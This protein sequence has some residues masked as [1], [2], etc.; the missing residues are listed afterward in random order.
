MQLASKHWMFKQTNILQEDVTIISP[1]EFQIMSNAWD[2]EL[3]ELVTAAKNKCWK[4]KNDH[5][6]FPPVVG[7][8]IK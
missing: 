3:E 8:W 2:K 7:Q 4:F 6:P 5:I 1:A